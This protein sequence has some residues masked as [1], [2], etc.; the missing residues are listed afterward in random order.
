MH[1]KNNGEFISMMN[2][3]YGHFNAYEL[4]FILTNLH[5]LHINTL[6]IQKTSDNNFICV[7][8]KSTVWLYQKEESEHQYVQ[9]KKH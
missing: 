8:D 2:G 7:V 3:S 6:S 1:M 9:S 5:D 4:W